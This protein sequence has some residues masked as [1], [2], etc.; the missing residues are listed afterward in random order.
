M[1]GVDTGRAGR[2][3]VPV[4]WMPSCFCGLLRVK[5]NREKTG[6]RRGVLRLPLGEWKGEMM[7]RGRKRARAGPSGV[8]VARS[9]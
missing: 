3:V 4:D 1:D 7:V 8:L 5:S 6:D 2:G 9:Q